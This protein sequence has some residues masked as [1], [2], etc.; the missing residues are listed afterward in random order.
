MERQNV[1]AL[2]IPQAG[3]KLGHSVNVIWRVG[4][5]GHENKSNPDWFVPFC[6]SSRKTKN[7]AHLCS[8]HPKMT[9]WIEALDVKQYQVDHVQFFVC[10]TIAEAPVC[11]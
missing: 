9:F 4:V 10:Q 2:H 6:K 3:G 5:S 7:R 11:V 8:G 1:D